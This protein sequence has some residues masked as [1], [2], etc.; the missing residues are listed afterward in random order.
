MN[1][2]S[3]KN[4]LFRQD[5][6]FLQS[7]EPQYNYDDYALDLKRVMQETHQTARN[8]LIEKKDSNIQLLQIITI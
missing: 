5:S 1:W 2:F 8:N 7:P 4:L 6:Y 3:G